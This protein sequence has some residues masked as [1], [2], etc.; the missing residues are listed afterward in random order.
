M[1]K[2]PFRGNKDAFRLESIVPALSP[3][4]RRV[5]VVSTVDEEADRYRSSICV[6]ATDGS[7]AA[8]P[9]TEGPFG[10]QS[11]MVSRRRVAPGHLGD[12]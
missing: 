2:R 7:G 9:F 3:D 8:R 10:P 6:A 1:A 4:G 5:R 11:P 12:R